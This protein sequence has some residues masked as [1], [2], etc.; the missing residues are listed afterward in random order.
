MINA[1]IFDLDGTLL[2]TI[3]DL[4]DAVNHTFAAYGREARTEA[5]V[6]RNVGRGIRNLIAQSLSL[7]RDDPDYEAIFRDFKSYYTVNCRN[8]TAPY[9]GI[10]EMLVMLKDAGL[11]TAVVSNKNDEAARGLVSYFFGDLIDV[12]AG[13]TENVKPKPDPGMIRSAMERIGAAPSETVYVGDQEVDFES[14]ENAGLPLIAAGWGFRGEKT[15]MEFARKTGRKKPAV[16]RRPE[17]I[18]ELIL[19]R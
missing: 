6:K 8:R 16:A 9:P 14:A 13:A 17:D 4:A 18:A 7:G 3:G 2:D 12:C 19:G 5:Q 1:V 10:D 11:A 15:L